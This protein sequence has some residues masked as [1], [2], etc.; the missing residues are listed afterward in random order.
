MTSTLANAIWASRYRYSRAGVPVDADL[1]DT[2]ARV[3]GAIAGAE[4]EPES[5]SSRYRD[6]L[7]GF[8]FLPGGRVL[9]GAGTD[10][11]VTLFNCFVS[12]PVDDSIA[13][14]LDS[15]KETA[16]TMQQGGGVGVDF[17]DLRPRG[18]VALK[19]G[20]IASGP[21]S[22]MR[23]WDSLCETLL[24]TSS[25]RGAM[26]GALR[27]DHPDI[28]EF[29]EAKR[30]P[31]TLRN[32]NLSVLITDGFMEAVANDASWALTH[33]KGDTVYAEVDAKKNA[34]ATSLRDALAG[35]LTVFDIAPST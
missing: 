27:C 25:R 35:R 9:A 14:I 22:F 23:I 16:V 32:F 18:D 21:V 15:L 12:G 1:E 26:I 7:C 31:G 2:F 34:F 24:A 11:Q 19:T 29:V 8:R 6:E 3:A 20:A 30:D 13:G 17:S 10:R 4:N 28:V 5:W 33:P